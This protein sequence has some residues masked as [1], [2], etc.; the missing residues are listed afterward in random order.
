MFRDDLISFK[1]FGYGLYDSVSGFVM[2]PVRGA[3]T[4]GT[5]GFAKGVGKGLGGLVFKPAAGACGLPGYAFKGIFEEV[6]KLGKDR[7]QE[8][9]LA[10]RIADGEDRCARLTAEQRTA[11]VD[12]WNIVSETKSTC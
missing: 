3:Q 2:Q 9:I 6:R 8:I 1:G 11:I 10:A 12:G 4:G 5:A 7:A